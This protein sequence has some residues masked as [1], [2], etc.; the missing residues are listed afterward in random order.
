[1]LQAPELALLQVRLLPLT[2]D[3]DSI[4][5]FRSLRIQFSYQVETSPLRLHSFHFISL[6]LHRSLPSSRSSPAS[7]RI[8]LDRYTNKVYSIAIVR[9]ICELLTIALLFKTKEEG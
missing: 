6:H 2:S 1:M 5:F 7:C 9:Y 8:S 4:P 3:S